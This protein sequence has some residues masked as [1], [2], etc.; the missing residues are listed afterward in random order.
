[1]NIKNF[2]ID[3]QYILEDNGFETCLMTQSEVKQTIQDNNLETCF[4][5]ISHEQ[6]NDTNF[7]ANINDSLFL[8]KSE[9]NKDWICISKDGNIISFI[10]I[11]DT[12]DI[13]LIISVFE[14]NN[15]YRGQGYAKNIINIFENCAKDKKYKCIFLTSFDTDSC[16]FWEHMDFKEAGWL[17]VKNI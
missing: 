1:M 7:I 15:N 2:L 10:C 14:I 4:P 16:Y 6:S 8:N 5:M 3:F 17:Y 11:D 9:Y 12:N 13:N